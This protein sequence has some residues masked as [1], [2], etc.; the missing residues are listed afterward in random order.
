MKKLLLISLLIV[1]ALGAKAQVYDLKSDTYLL[2]SDTVVNTAVVNLTSPE[3]SGAKQ[4]LSFQVEVTEISGTTAGTLTLQGS[5][6]GSDFKAIPTVET[7]TSVT[8]ASPADVSTKQV[9]LW[10]F[11]SNHFRYY[12]VAY[13]GAGTMSAR[14]F[15]QLMVR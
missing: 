5:L 13:A 7:Q 8:T 10:R 14:F 1:F 6:D 15:A 3:I 12:R 4:I 2:T 9:F 11:T